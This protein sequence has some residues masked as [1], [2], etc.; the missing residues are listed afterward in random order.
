M[1]IR[2][3][4]IIYGDIGRRDWKIQISCIPQ[5]VHM[6]HAL[7]FLVVV[8]PWSIYPPSSGLLHTGTVAITRFSIDNDSETT[9]KYMGR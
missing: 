5:I 3:V 7:L 1:L 2:Y 6:F 8:I 9:L 4:R